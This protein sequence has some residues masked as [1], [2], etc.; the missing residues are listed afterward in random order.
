MSSFGQTPTQETAPPVR[1]PDLVVSVDTQDLFDEQPRMERFSRHR[2]RVLAEYLDSLQPKGGLVSLSEY[3]KKIEIYPH[4]VNAALRVLTK[5]GGRA[6]L[7]DE[8]GLGKTIEAGIVL[9]EMLSRGLVESVIIL[10][11]S[12]LVRQWQEELREKFGERFRTHEDSDFPG[13][14]QAERVIASIDTAKL[15]ENAAKILGREWDLVIVDEAHYLKSRSTLRY[16]LVSKIESKYFLGLTAT[17]IQNNLRELFNLIH[18]VRPGLLGS[19]RTFDRRFIADAE[20]RQLQNVNELQERL[21]EVIIRNR[22]NETGLDFPTRTVKTHSV[23][24]SEKEYQLHDE[25]HDFIKDQ[26]DN[27][28][29]ML[30]LLLLQREMTSSPQAVIETLKRMQRGGDTM[31]GK[32]LEDLLK[33]ASSIRSSSKGDLL[34]RL[35]QKT[36][37]RFIVYTQFRKTQENLVQRL[38]RL[39]VNAIPFHGQLTP[40]RRQRAIQ[41]FRETGGALII[42]DSGSE[43]LNLQFCHIVVNYDLPWNPMRVEQRIGRVHRIGQVEDVLILNLAVK[44][45]VEDYVL[46]I[47]YEKIRLFEVAIGEMDLILSDLESGETLEKQVFDILAKSPNRTGQK[48][49]L[50]SLKRKIQK[51]VDKAEKVKVFDESVF[52]QFDLGTTEGA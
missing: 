3:K 34:E 38:K 14:D 49:K 45:T 7:A 36:K 21:R 15:E 52:S 22:R 42:T 9:K 24:G 50:S 6:I 13:F 25:L 10:T 4:Q 47:L 39:G 5:M 17:P 46:K 29:F 28:G 41:E 8:V 43:G 18:I 23:Q 19:A 40:G 33:L 30:S 16:K 20:G 44:D 31:G 27:Q 37:N 32:E 26:Y 51:G 35:A 12:N 2:L 11:P 1:P 48:R